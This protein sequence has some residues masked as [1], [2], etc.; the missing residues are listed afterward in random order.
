MRRGSGRGRIGR[1]RYERVGQAERRTDRS[2]ERT[3]CGPITLADAVPDLAVSDSIVDGAVAAAGA[4]ARVQSSTLFD[5][6]AVPRCARTIRSRGNVRV[7]AQRGQMGCPFC[8]VPGPRSACRAATAAGP[9]SRC[10]DV[11]T[12]RRADRGLGRRSRRSAYGDPAYGQLASWLPPEIA[13]GPRTAPRSAPF[14]SLK[15]PQREANLR[16]SL[17][18]YLRSGLDAGIFFVT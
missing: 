16:T 7:A 15:Q 10:G 17:D 6:C 18:E 11:Q 12:T 4:T 14:S 2:L 13:T 5:A 9:I 8:Y 3:I 1:E